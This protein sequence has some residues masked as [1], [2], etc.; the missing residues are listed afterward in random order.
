MVN[1]AGGAFAAGI[2]GPAVETAG[3]SRASLRDDGSAECKHQ[4]N[5]AEPLRIELVQRLPGTEPSSSL[6]NPLKTVA[7]GASPAVTARLGSPGRGCP[8]HE[9]VVAT[10]FN[11][12]LWPRGDGRPIVER[13]A[14]GNE[15]LHVEALR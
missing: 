5:I 10:F 8:G 4:L 3:Y 9:S 13:E 1:S 11:G 12:R 14:V 7:A 6:M 2:V 15:W